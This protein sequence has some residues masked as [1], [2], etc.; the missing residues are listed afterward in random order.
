MIKSRGQEQR[1]RVS[2]LHQRYSAAAAACCAR[3]DQ[4]T[5]PNAT[6]YTEPIT[7]KPAAML[8]R[9]AMHGPALNAARF[10]VLC[11]RYRWE[12]ERAPS[13]H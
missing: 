11:Y 9:D 7:P 5:L 1:R 3:I 4:Q 10:F 12:T 8:M 2:A 6:A 13:L